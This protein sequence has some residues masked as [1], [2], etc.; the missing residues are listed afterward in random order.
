MMKSVILMLVI[1]RSE[2]LRALKSN[3]RSKS[4]EV[5]P[6]EAAVSRRTH[7]LIKYSDQAR[8]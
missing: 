3:N 2:Q 5:T 6:M 4:R 8:P 7:Y 1:I